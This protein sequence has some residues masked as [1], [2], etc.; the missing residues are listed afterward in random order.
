M[1]PLAVLALSSVVVVSVGCT[2]GG[3]GPSGLASVR[4]AIGG[5]TVTVKDV[6]GFTGSQTLNGGTRAYAG[7]LISDT[8]G[9]CAAA[10]DKGVTAV[11]TTANILEVVATTP[12]DMLTAGKYTVGSSGL[13]EYFYGGAAGT[14]SGIAGGGT[15]TFDS[16]DGSAVKGS[17]DLVMAGGAHVTGTFSA[18][19]CNGIPPNPF[20]W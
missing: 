15:V 13:A 3:S 8:P 16:V 9:T 18:P 2:S 14:T 7:L 1:K 19:V 17:F 12:G 10:Q 6:M 11:E 5:H 4:G 20:P